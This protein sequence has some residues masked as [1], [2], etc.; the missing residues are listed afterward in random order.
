MLLA[1][2]GE[3]GAARVKVLDF[4]I[5]KVSNE[6]GTET[7]AAVGSPLWMAPEQAQRGRLTPATDVFALALIAFRV[8]TGRM[9]WL[10]ATHARPAIKEVLI[11][12][13]MK[14]LPPASSRAKALGATAP[15]PGGFDAW[16][17]RAVER[18][19][20]RRFHD[21]GAAWKALA[22]VLAGEVPAAPAPEPTPPIAPD[23]DS[24]KTVSLTGPRRR[25]AESES[26]ATTSPSP[27]PATHS[28]S[29]QP[30]AHPA[31]PQRSVLRSPTPTPIPDL[32]QAARVER[33][34]TKRSPAFIVTV[35]AVG[36]VL[37]VALVV[38]ITQRQ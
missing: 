18:D 33:G 24:M 10:S 29:P 15:L 5:S 23:E 34:P 12:L 28:P 36:V 1:N 7:T 8:L 17:D 4:G 2:E 9:Y 35:V 13:L 14:P 25:V 26:D 21:A 30:A 3:G 20:A 16:F 6:A 11:E 37:L 38:V 22:P 32:L 31:A 19:P 27:S